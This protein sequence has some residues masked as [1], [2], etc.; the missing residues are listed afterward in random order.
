MKKLNIVN[1]HIKQTIIRIQIL[2]QLLY[3]KTSS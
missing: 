3:H 2:S 1:E